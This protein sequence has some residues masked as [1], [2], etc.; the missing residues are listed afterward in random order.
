MNPGFE[1]EEIEKLKAECLEEGQNFVLVD[2][3]DE[4]ED[5]G[6]FYHFQFV[7]QYEGKEVIYDAVLSTLSLHHSSLVYEEAENK[8]MKIYKDY[9]PFE[10]RTDKTNITEDAEQMLMEF[11]EEI[12]ADETIKVSEF[13]DIDPD[14]DFGVGIEAALNLDEIDLETIEK[15]IADFNAGKLKLD[16]T[17][18]SFKN[19]FED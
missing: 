17:L 2:D 10:D 11:I 15:F 8:V 5:E 1:K 7:G 6:E 3:E 9:V 19:G 18:Y 16:K 4:F 13:V 12:E 14:F